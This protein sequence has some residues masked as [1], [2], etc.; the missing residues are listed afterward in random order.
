MSKHGKRF[1]RSVTR[2]LPDYSGKKD[3]MGYLYSLLNRRLLFRYPSARRRVPDCLMPQTPFYATRQRRMSLC[4][5]LFLPDTETPC[6]VICTIPRT[7]LVATG[8]EQTLD[9]LVLAHL[10]PLIPLFLLLHDLPRYRRGGG[11]FD[12]VICAR[13]RFAVRFGLRLLVFV[14]GGFGFRGCAVSVRFGGCRVAVC[15]FVGVLLALLTARC[16][17]QRVRE[18]LFAECLYPEVQTRKIGWYGGQ[19]RDNIVLGVR[20]ITLSSLALH[21]PQSVAQT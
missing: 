21:H 12:S 9:S 6:H 5:P 18:A 3:G 20:L 15:F 16:F 2:F 10:P 8:I 1:E 4:V 13:F 17:L 7:R 19:N 11:V 14:R